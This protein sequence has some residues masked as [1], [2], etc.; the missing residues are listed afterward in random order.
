MAVQVE[1]ISQVSHLPTVRVGI[2]P[3]GVRAHLFPLH[4]WDLHD[5]R[6]VIYG[7]ADAT[8]VLTEPKDVARYVELF[9]GV[10]KMAVFG[11]EAREV[12]AG[13]AEDYRS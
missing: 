11:D 13:I 10:A 12:L 2:V 8:A 4:G 3:W 1:H 6:A 9:E 7:T 5:D